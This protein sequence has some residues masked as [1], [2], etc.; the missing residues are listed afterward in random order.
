MKNFKVKGSFK[1]GIKW[2]NFTK[3]V[4][5]QNKKNAIEKVYSLFGSKH[6][7]KRTFI[8]INSVEEEP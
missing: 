1:A 3:S 4:T 5:S 8:K 6:K 7:L 2:E